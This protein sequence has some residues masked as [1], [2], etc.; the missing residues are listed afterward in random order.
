MEL[1]HV[2]ERKQKL[3]QNW[4]KI[5][6]NV[7]YTYSAFQHKSSFEFMANSSFFLYMSAYILDMWPIIKSSYFTSDIWMCEWLP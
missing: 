6:E 2:L 3:K 1:D 7:A 5:T 4:Q